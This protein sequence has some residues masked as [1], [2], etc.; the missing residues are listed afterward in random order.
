M[1]YRLKKRWPEEQLTGVKEIKLWCQK[2]IKWSGKS[3]VKEISRQ[4]SW[5]DRGS[6]TV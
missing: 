6:F 3:D 5:I 2:V 1:P 4:S